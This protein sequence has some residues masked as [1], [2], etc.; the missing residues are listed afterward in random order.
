MRDIFIRKVTFQS[1]GDKSFVLQG[2]LYPCL[3]LIQITAHWQPQRAKSTLRKCYASLV[4]NQKSGSGDPTL[5][6]LGFCGCN[7]HHRAFQVSTLFLSNAL[8]NNDL[9]SMMNYKKQLKIWRKLYSL[10]TFIF[11]SFCVFVCFS[12]CFVL[13]VWFGSV[14]CWKPNTNLSLHLILDN[15]EIW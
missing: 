5:N 10:N 7:L 11:L 1:T 12:F 13:F 14:F 4:V 8:W 2:D 3:Q 6:F 9:W 15:S